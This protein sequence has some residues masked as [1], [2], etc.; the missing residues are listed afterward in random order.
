MNAL[1]REVVAPL[2]CRFS[3]LA[4]RI[5]KKSAV[6]ETIASYPA[7]ALDFTGWIDSLLFPPR[8]QRLNQLFFRIKQPEDN[9]SPSI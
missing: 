1:Q 2:V 9:P 4:T 7:T 3:S 5:L 8:S 6:A